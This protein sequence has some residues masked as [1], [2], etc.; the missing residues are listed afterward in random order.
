MDLAV[1]L[2][3]VHPERRRRHR[4]APVCRRECLAHRRDRVRHADQAA[5]VIAVKDP[6][7]PASSS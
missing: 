1:G 5:N 4:V 7:H 6:D 3:Q 2:G